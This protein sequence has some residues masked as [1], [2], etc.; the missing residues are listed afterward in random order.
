V[1][2]DLLGLAPTE[3]RGFEVVNAGSAAAGDAPPAHVT[4]QNG[5]EQ[6]GTLVVFGLL[7][8]MGLALFIAPFACG[9]PDGLEKTAEVFG[10][11]ER[12]QSRLVSAPAADYRVPGVASESV[13][14]GIAG[15]AGTIVV[16]GV[17]WTLATGLVRRNKP[18]GAAERAASSQ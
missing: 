8:S 5:R 17:V 7:I 16:F 1:R 11:K 18:E 9:W 15:A 6:A 14:T 2:P 4:P 12:E 10:F 3:A 13:A